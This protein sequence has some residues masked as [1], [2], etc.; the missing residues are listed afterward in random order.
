ML[1]SRSPTAVECPE[2]QIENG[3]LNEEP[4][5]VGYTARYSCNDGYRLVGKVS[6][7]CLP[8]GTWSDENPTCEGKA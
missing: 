6:R 7:T 5:Y 1:K 8:N 3:Y 4:R 2:P